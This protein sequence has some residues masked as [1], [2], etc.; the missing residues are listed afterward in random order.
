[1]F[2]CAIIIVIIY[3]LYILYYRRNIRVFYTIDS[4][5]VKRLNEINKL[6]LGDIIYVQWTHVPLNMTGPHKSNRNGEVN[7]LMKTK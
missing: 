2:G 7:Y 5:C 3:Y 6:S 1:M 4:K